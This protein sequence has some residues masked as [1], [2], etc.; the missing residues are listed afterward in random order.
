MKYFDVELFLKHIK[1]KHKLIETKDISDWLN[2]SVRYIQKWAS[3]ND[4]EFK[5][6]HGRKYYIWNE[7]G[8]DLSRLQE[9]FERNNDKEEPEPII[10]REH[11]V[12][13]RTI[14][15]VVKNKL[16]NAGV[17]TLQI[18]CKKYDV[19]YQYHYGRKYYIMSDEII[20][21]YKYAVKNNIS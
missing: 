21:L 17:R 19:P 14:N 7:E 9:W 5:R 6:I 15:D 20:E 1:K 11:K 8:L 16:L 3:N 4:I 18:W 13:F 2:V 10:K 12:N